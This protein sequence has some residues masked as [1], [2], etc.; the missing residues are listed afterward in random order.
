MGLEFAG[1]ALILGAIGY[2]IDYSIG[3]YPVGTV[4][5]LVLGVVGGMYRFIREALLANKRNMRQYEQL[6]EAHRRAEQQREQ[7]L[8]GSGEAWADDDEPRDSE[9]PR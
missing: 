6:H 9:G 2:Y 8:D 4:I 3:S 7:G 5:G 1:A